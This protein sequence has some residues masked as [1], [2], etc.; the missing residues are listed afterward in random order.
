V[1]QSRKIT[2]LVARIV[3]LLAIGAVA[4][5]DAIAQETPLP[6]A[7]AYYKRGLDHYNRADTDRAIA[8]FDQAI[9]VDPKFAKAYLKRGVAYDDKGDI[10]RAIADYTKAIKLE[11]CRPFQRSPGWCSMRP[12]SSR[13]ETARASRRNSR[14]MKGPTWSRRYAHSEGFPS[15]ITRTGSL[16]LATQRRAAAR[17]GSGPVSPIQTH[18]P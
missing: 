4:T 13:P 9:K 2:H 18:R 3:T 8:D 1:S 10:D 5:Q 7:Q 14:P 15:R 12:T 16:I 17:D 6:N 11:N